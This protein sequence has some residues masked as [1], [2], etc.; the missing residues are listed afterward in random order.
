MPADRVLGN[1]SYRALTLR[2]RQ[3]TRDAQSSS[4]DYGRRVRAVRDVGKHVRCD[5]ALH[6][7]LRM[8]NVACV[9]MFVHACVCVCVSLS[10][11]LSLSRP[12]SPSLTFPISLP[13]LPPQKCELLCCES[14]LYWYNV[15]S[16]VMNC[17]V[18][19]KVFCPPVL[20]S[21]CQNNCHAQTQASERPLF[22]CSRS[23]P[24]FQWWNG[25]R[26]ELRLCFAETWSLTFK[27]ASNCVKFM[28]ATRLVI[29]RLKFG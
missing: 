4:C 16:I 13:H 29:S 26:A 20:P 6:C 24:F 28:F 5:A 18:H 1:A 15:P 7:H 2:K 19:P 3:R 10:L 9:Y 12:P 23:Q 14:A 8:Q 25:F 21:S 17:Y 11:S 22:R 27:S